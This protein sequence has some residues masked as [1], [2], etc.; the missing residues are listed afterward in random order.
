MITSGVTGAS[1]VSADAV[2]GGEGMQYLVAV[3]TGLGD[4]TVALKLTGTGIFDLAGNPFL[5][6]QDQTTYASGSNPNSV[7]I[8]DLDGDGRGDLVVANYGGVVSRC[9]LEAATVCSKNK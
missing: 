6:F 8:G 1:I 5:G 9:F 2:P 7:A 3:N 4:G